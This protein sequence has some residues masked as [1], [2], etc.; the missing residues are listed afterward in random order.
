MKNIILSLSLFLIGC[1]NPYLRDTKEIDHKLKKCETVDCVIDAMDALP[2]SN[3]ERYKFMEGYPDT[4]LRQLKESGRLNIEIMNPLLI[5]NGVFSYIYYVPGMYGGMYGCDVR[6]I[7]GFNWVLL[8]HELAH[9]QGYEDKGIPLMYSD[10]T[11]E[12]KMIMKNEKVTKWTDTTFYKNYNKIINKP[13]EIA[14]KSDIDF[15]NQ[16]N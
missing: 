10:Y 12:Q 7:P 4:N 5:I 1:T 2:P 16:S 14:R 13:I 9:C 15:L 8:A 11:E 6:Y 3:E